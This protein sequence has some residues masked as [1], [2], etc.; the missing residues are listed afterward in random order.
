[1]ATLGLERQV[2]AQPSLQKEIY[3]LTLAQTTLAAVVARRLKDRFHSAGYP[4]IPVFVR[5]DVT[6][7]EHEFLEDLLHVVY[8]GL[9]RWK[10]YNEF[11]SKKNYADYVKARFGLDEGCRINRRLDLIRKA[12][13]RRLEVRGED[14]RIFLII[15]GMDLCSQTLLL[16]LETELSQLRGLGVSLLLTSRIPVFEQDVFHCDHLKHT[17]I[18]PDED[19]QADG[20]DNMDEEADEPMDEQ[21]R[22]NEDMFYT[23]ESCSSILC[24][25]CKAAERTCDSNI[26]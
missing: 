2:T 7:Y 26:W 21:G 12:L 5:E 20:E 25:G 11:G 8:Q 4:V 19:V 14:T 22:R 10:G 24:L 1:L 23:C 15:D 17:E 3:E 9:G 16:L 13:H 18:D 6:T